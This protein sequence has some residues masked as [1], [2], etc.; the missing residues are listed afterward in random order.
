MHSQ[1]PSACKPGSHDPEPRDTAFGMAMV[2]ATTL[3]LITAT[4]AE[5]PEQHFTASDP[6][7]A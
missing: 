5:E 1:H 3:P 2:P 4:L 7:S 6:S